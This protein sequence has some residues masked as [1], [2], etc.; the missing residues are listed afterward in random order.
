MII[1]HDYLGQFRLSTLPSF[2]SY[3]QF[4]FTFCT[5]L[6]LEYFPSKSRNLLKLQ[7]SRKKK[8][9]SMTTTFRGHA[10]SGWDQFRIKLMKCSKLLLL[11]SAALVRF[12]GVQRHILLA[13]PTFLL[14]KFSVLI[15]NV[16]KWWNLLMISFTFYFKRCCIKT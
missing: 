6:R 13:S 4:L 16:K 10:W 1:Y 12:F 8:L 11:I 2:Y 14:S 7:K 5:Y 3:S 9:L 15:K